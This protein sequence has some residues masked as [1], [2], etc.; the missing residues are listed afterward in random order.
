[1]IYNVLAHSIHNLTLLNNKK[2]NF[3]I[4]IQFKNLL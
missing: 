4:S 3:S 2:A 1:M